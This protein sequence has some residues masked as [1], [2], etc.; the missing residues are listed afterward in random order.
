MVSIAVAII[1]FHDLSTSLC[2]KFPVQFFSPNTF[3][4]TIS[5]CMRGLII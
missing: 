3:S 1:M 4:K 2:A 5:Y